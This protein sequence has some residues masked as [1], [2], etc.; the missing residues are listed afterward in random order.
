[1]C[2]DNE[3]A[4]INETLSGEPHEH[5]ILIELLGDVAIGARGEA[6]DLFEVCP[7]QRVAGARKADHDNGVLVHCFLL[8]AK[9]LHGG[10]AGNL[11]FGEEVFFEAGERLLR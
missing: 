7:E 11:G 6:H 2:L 9:E 5:E 10:L 3:D 4:L 1:M 8:E